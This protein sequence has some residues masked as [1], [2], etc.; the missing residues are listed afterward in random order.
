[1]SDVRGCYRAEVYKHYVYRHGHSLASATGR[2][3]RSRYVLHEKLEGDA[4]ACHWCGVDLDWSTLCADHL[5]SDI[6]NDVPENLVASCRGCN[7]NRSD[8]TG[9]GRRRPKACAHCGEM[10]LRLGRQSHHKRQR[11]CSQSCATTA[12]VQRGSN[13]A[14]GTRTRYVSGCRC[15]ECRAANAAYSRQI[16][17]RTKESHERQT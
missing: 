1:M 5:D 6:E 8:G 16:V 7:A 15:D 13:S 14:H 4:G 12:T 3:R 11:Y 9:L 17:Q 2:V 10:F